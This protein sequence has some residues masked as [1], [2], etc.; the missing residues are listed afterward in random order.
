MQVLYH[1]NICPFSRKVRFVLNEKKVPFTLHSEKFWEK[2]TNFLKLNPAGTVPLL[3]AKPN[4]KIIGSQNII[5]FFEE[6][7]NA[8]KLI[9][10]N[11][12][13]K[14][15]IRRII[16]WFDEKF[17]NEV[18]KIF[19]EEKILKFLE[20]KEAPHSQKLSSA[21]DAL[22]RHMQY[23]NYLLS[24]NQWITGSKITLADLTAA[25]HISTIDYLG[26]IRWD[27]YEL[28]KEWYSVVKSRPSFQDIL[29]DIVVGFPPVKHYKE[30]DF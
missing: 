4:I 22:G 14:C 25:A 8:P 28:V 12:L 18:S 13:E 2:R 27:K 23:L 20:K 7:N 3:I 19:L 1:Y 24:K 30:L 17:Y 6:V 15:E 5:D 26:E 9:C 10:G 29:Q 16:S 21:S 11:P